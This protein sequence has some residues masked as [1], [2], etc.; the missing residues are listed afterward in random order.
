[1]KQNPFASNSQE[2]D[3]GRLEMKQNP[4]ASNS[5]WSDFGRLEMKQKPFALKT[6]KTLVGF[7]ITHSRFKTTKNQPWRA[8]SFWRF[9]KNFRIHL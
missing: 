2:S 5:Q 4:F 7:Y 6:G 1:M 3:S 8:D 9:M